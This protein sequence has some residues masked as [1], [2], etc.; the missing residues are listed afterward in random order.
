MSRTQQPSSRCRYAVIALAILSGFGITACGESGPTS[1]EE[2]D[3]QDQLNFF[4]QDLVGLWYRY[5]SYDGSDQYIRFNADRTACKWEEPS[6]S[7]A[8]VATSSYSRWSIDDT[9]APASMAIAVQGAGITW[10][11]DYPDDEIWPSGYR[12]NLTRRPS[13]SSKTCQ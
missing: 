4:E 13:S 12:S 5:H 9:Q 3:A 2:D 11:F 6:G 10:M 7:N 8:R 1:L